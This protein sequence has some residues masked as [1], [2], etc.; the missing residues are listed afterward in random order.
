MCQITLE[1]DD[2]IIADAERVASQASTTL[3]DLIRQFVITIAHQTPSNGATSIDALE[4][5]F[6][7]LSRDMEQR[8]WTRESLYER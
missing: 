2:E 4:E 3:V 6:A 8:S 5:S 1:L 7:N